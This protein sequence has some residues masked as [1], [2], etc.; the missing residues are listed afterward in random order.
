MRGG[1][2]NV[3][4]SHLRLLLPLLQRLPPP[5]RPRRLPEARPQRP[6]APRRDGATPRQAARE[7]YGAV[8]KHGEV[9]NDG[10][11]GQRPF[12]GPVPC[13]G[14]RGRGVRQETRVTA[15]VLWTGACECFKRFWGNGGG[16]TAAST[17]EASTRDAWAREARPSPAPPPLPGGLER[18]HAERVERRVAGG[19]FQNSD[20]AGGGAPAWPSA[21]RTAS[22]RVHRWRLLTVAAVGHPRLLLALGH[23]VFPP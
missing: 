9:T 17:R 11:A 4:L 14:H 23:P 5:P 20:A 21:R 12:E 10:V 3:L 13:R 6:W 18:V 22:P 8:P 19:P 7:Q 15:Y 2:S 1:G 16:A